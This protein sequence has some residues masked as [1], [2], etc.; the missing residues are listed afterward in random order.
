M[1][2]RELGSQSHPPPFHPTPTPP[3]SSSTTDTTTQ[4]PHEPALESESHID[5]QQRLQLDNAQD[6][7][8]DYQVES[9]T[10]SDQHP[11]PAQCVQ[12]PH[13]TVGEVLT[14]GTSNVANE[15]TS[16]ELCTASV[17][18]VR[19]SNDDDGDDGEDGMVKE[20]SGAVVSTQSICEDP[21]KG[22]C[23]LDKTPMHVMSDAY[24]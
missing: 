7:Y 23:M 12:P 22:T 5:I 3:I 1:S 19:G 9:C 10:A 8:S 14:E 13:E 17:Q 16:D 2:P 6:I 20:I 11:P 4:S 21:V 18:G 15:E 24:H